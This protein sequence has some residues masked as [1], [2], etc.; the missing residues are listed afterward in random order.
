M[1]THCL[2]V[3]EYGAGHL[4]AGRRIERDRD[5]EF[6]V[7]GPVAGLVGRARGGRQRLGADLATVVPSAPPR[8][9][10]MAEYADLP[11]PRTHGGGLVHLFD[12][13]AQHRGPMEVTRDVPR[14]SWAKPA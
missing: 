14:A 3:I 5:A 9:I 6:V 12:E 7:A 1:L 11:P 2:G 8:G 13:L 4:V 10:P